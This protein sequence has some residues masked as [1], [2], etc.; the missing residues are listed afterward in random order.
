VS[1]VSALSGGTVLMTVADVRT[2]IVKAGINE[3]DIGKV[4]EKQGVKVSL[5]AYP[6]I[7]FKRCHPAHL[8][9]GSA[10]GKGQGLRRRDRHRK[11]GGRAPHRD[12][13]NIDVLG[14]SRKNVLTVPIEALFRKDE[15]E[16]VYVKKAPDPKAASTPGFIARAFAG[17]KND[18]KDNDN[19]KKLDPK[20]QWQIQFEAARGRDRSGQPRQ[21][22][23]RQ[24]A[25]GRRGSR[26]RRSDATQGEERP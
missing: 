16:I 19:K 15:K 7:R 26:R 4:R 13:G 14:E 9:G 25:Q 8:P 10:R 24:G 23:D 3:V 2:M 17:E 12:D 1:G 21:D 22:R 20:D 6:K 18:S 11:A 5:D